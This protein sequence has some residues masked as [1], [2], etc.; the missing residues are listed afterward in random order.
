MKHPLM[1]SLSDLSIDDII[2]KTSDLQKKLNQALRFGN[3]NLANQINMVL[4]GYKEEYQKR[5]RDAAEKAQAD[6]ELKEK[7]LRERDKNKDKK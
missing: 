1:E 3:Q 5:M 6:K 7:K 4:E 2:E